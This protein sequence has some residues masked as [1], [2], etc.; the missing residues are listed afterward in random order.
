MT[1]ACTCRAFEDFR[2]PAPPD[3]AMTSI[4]SRGDGCL[5]WRCCIVDYADNI[6]VTGSHTGMAFERT[7]YR[8]I[9]EALAVP[10][11]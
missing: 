8:A 3:V 11:R 4:Y 5:R 9:A 7:S 6:E 2:A 1:A 10:E